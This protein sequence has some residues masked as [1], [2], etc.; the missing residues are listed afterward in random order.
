MARSQLYQSQILQVKMRWKALA[1]IYTM[2]RSLISKFS[3]KFASFFAKFASV[4]L[5]FRQIDEFS[6]KFS[7]NFHFH[8]NLKPEFR[9]IGN[10]KIISRN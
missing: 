1:E 3:S 10:P 5:I 9:E 2:H 6:P 4:L 8:I 7:R